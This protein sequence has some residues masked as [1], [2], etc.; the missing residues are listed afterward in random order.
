MKTQLF[1]KGHLF[2]IFSTIDANGDGGLSREEFLKGCLQDQVIVIS[3]DVVTTSFSWVV[4]TSLSSTP[5]PSSSSSS[6]S[7]IPSLSSSRSS[8]WSLEYHHYDHLR[9]YGPLKIIKINHE[10]PGLSSIWFQEYYY[11]HLDR[12]WGP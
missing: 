6:W 12:P 1:N 2:R 4:Y 3:T 9:I 10:V 7:R 8:T 5:S 11:H